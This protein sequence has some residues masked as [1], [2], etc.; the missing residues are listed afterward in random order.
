M[1]TKNIV[2]S[3]GKW[4]RKYALLILILVM[5]T[6]ELVSVSLNGMSPKPQ[7]P[8]NGYV[9]ESGSVTMQ[10][11]KGNID[12]PITLQLS[13]T[14]DFT[15]IVLERKVTGTTTSYGDSLERGVTYY[16]R[17]MQDEIPSAVS[18]FSVSKQHIK[19]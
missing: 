1:Y 5:L 6:T 9:V 8:P 18:K 2:I 3:T 15:D 7:L 16:W 11:N 14:E 13:K 12:K 10:W 19:L 4:L 17:L